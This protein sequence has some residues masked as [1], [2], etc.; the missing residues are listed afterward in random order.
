MTLPDQRAFA[1]RLDGCYPGAQSCC[2]RSAWDDRLTDPD[3]GPDAV[4]QRMSRSSL[5]FGGG[6]DRQVAITGSSLRR[7]LTVSCPFTG[8]VELGC[9]G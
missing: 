5:I 7:A 2:P 4:R 9:R 1:I 6:H 8:P 3:N